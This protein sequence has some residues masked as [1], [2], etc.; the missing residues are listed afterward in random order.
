MQGCFPLFKDMGCVISLLVETD[1]G[2]YRTS[3]KLT[4]TNCGL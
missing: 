2:L 4:E 1:E 3:Q